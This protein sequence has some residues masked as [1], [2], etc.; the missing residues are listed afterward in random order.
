VTAAHTDNIGSP[1][2][3]ASFNASTATAT[4]SWQTDQ[5]AARGSPYTV[6]FEA[7]ETELAATVDVIIQVT[8]VNVPPELP[9]HAAPA[10]GARV[11]T[12]Q[13][14]LRI[15]NSTDVD[16][17][18]LVYELELYQDPDLAP[19]HSDSV[20][21]GA[22]GETAWVPPA[23]LENTRY[24]WRVRAYDG[25]LDNP[26]S[27]WTTAWRFLV[28]VANDPPEPPVMSKPDGSQVVLSRNPTLEAINPT[29]PEDDPLELT[30]EVGLDA[31]FSTS[32]AVSPPQPVN[33]ASTTTAW[34]L[35]TPLDW[36]TTYYVRAWAT[37]DR[38]GRSDNSNVLSFSL[39]Q[40]Q[41]PP[42]PELFTPFDTGCDAGVAVTYP[43]API[44]VVN[45][46]DPDG[47]AVWLDLEIYDA[48]REPDAAAPVFALSLPQSTGPSTNFIVDSSELVNGTLYLVRARANDTFEQSDWSSCQFIAV[49]NGSATGG[50][51]CKA[52]HAGFGALLALALLLRRRR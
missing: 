21:E 24:T 31:D 39:R 3:E 23:L 16:F 28:D 33:A 44:T 36:S 27:P 6:T 40:N 7:A 52:G 30:F 11:A 14:E 32:I 47:D 34:R 49:V 51:D 2:S 46:L 42:T 8:G 35:A 29:D 38:G 37:D 13:P 10:D 20:A 19:V 9:V 1:V 22:S 5:V 12:D 43:L 18:P 17:D 26:Y 48:A 45:V 15:I 4:W 50:C 25:Q 41:P